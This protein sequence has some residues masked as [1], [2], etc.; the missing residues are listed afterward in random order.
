MKA[1][2]VEDGL[3][4]TPVNSAEQPIVHGYLNDSPSKS[5][6]QVTRCNIVESF[7]DLVS[8]KPYLPLCDLP[9]GGPHSRP[10]FE[11]L[12]LYHAH[13]LQ[14]RYTA[15]QTGVVDNLD[16]LIHIFIGFRN[17]LRNAEEVGGLCQQTHARG[18]EPMVKRAQAP[19][20]LRERRGFRSGQSA[21]SKNF[22]EL[23]LV[24]GG[25]WRGISC[26][27]RQKR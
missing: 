1:E 11:P 15:G 6:P 20:L 24:G 22:Y 14:S 19:I 12:S 23:V 3:T 17:L 4:C 25:L 26:C 16:D 7:V 21:E 10:E 18:A 8:G 13:G 5:T 2:R 27:R 9:E